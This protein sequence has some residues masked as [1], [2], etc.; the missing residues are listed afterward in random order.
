[1]LD[2]NLSLSCVEVTVLFSTMCWYLAVY[3][4]VMLPK[5]WTVCRGCF[6]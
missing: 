1:M 2:F 5:S 3:C 4:Y 6:S